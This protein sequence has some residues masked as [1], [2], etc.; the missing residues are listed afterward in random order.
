M[1][2]HS[3]A[4][5][6]PKHC[7]L[8][9]TVQD[10]LPPLCVW[11]FN[12]APPLQINTFDTTC[13]GYLAVTVCMTIDAGVL[14]VRW[15]RE[16]LESSWRGAPHEIGDAECAHN[17]P[18]TSG[19]PLPS[20]HAPHPQ[21]QGSCPYTHVDAIA[22]NRRYRTKYDAERAFNASGTSGTSYTSD[23]PGTSGTSGTPPPSSV[24]YYPC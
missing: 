12:R 9:A 4:H 2:D 5:P 21:T 16:S 20:V 22:R 11:S 8:C 7:L 24:Q 18:E 3:S 10:V 1:H 23:T 17:T 15:R 19:T 6:P 13:T 14:L